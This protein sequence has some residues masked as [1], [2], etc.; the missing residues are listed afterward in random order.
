M[1]EFFFNFL[2]FFRY[3]QTVDE[4]IDG[5]RFPVAQ[6]MPRTHNLVD[7]FL[8]ALGG[9]KCLHGSEK[10]NRLQLSA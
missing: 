1:I 7:D 8:T 9:R 6:A 10:A 2:I 4:Q 3:G 5:C